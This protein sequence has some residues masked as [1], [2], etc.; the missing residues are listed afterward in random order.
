MEGRRPDAPGLTGETA[1]RAGGPPDL[2]EEAPRRARRATGL[3]VEPAGL[4]DELAGDGAEPPG[5]G[6]EALGPRQYA[7]RS[8]ISDICNTRNDCSGYDLLLS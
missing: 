2:T 1:G 3:A 5:R 8:S 7:C 6:A 4:V